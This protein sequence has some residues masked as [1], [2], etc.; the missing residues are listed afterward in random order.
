MSLPSFDSVGLRSA[1]PTTSS[2][3]RLVKT[4]RSVALRAPSSAVPGM[5]IRRSRPCEAGK[6]THGHPCTTPPA[7][8]NARALGDGQHCAAARADWA[9][10]KPMLLFRLSGL[11]LLRLATR[12]LFSLLFHEPPRKTPSGAPRIS[13]SARN[14]FDPSAQQLANLHQCVDCKFI[15]FTIKKI[16]TMTQAHIQSKFI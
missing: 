6:R 14:R 11:F 10:R 5:T 3:Q 16:A 8:L 4:G 1:N 15:L 9:R 13:G 2:F 12:T 7:S